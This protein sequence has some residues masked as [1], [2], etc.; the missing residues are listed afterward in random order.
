MSPRI[1]ARVPMRQH[2]V[3]VPEKN[4][5][6][7]AGEM[8]YRHIVRSLLACDMISEVVIDTDSP[9]IKK[10]AAVNFPQVKVIERPDDLRADTISM[11]K[12][13]MHDVSC[14]DADYYLQTHSTNPLVTSQTIERAI[15]LFLDKQDSCDS[16]FSV[17]KIQK[18]LYD[19]QLKAVNHDPKVLLRTQDLEPLYEENS[20]IYI[21]TKAVLL[22]LKTRNV[23]HRVILFRFSFPETSTLRYGIREQ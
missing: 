19:G 7:F 5:R 22:E 16:L 4:Y 14:V 23:D 20:C 15:Q 13:L 6:L 10:D 3:R 11:N 8:L 1:V 12:V 18:R 21:F 2:S 9:V 17:T